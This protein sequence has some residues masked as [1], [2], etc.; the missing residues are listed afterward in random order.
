MQIKAKT[1]F[2][3]LLVAVVIAWIGDAK[4]IS[5]SKRVFADNDNAKVDSHVNDIDRTNRIEGIKRNEESVD[6]DPSVDKDENFMALGGDT[7]IV[8]R[9]KRDN[10]DNDD[11]TVTVER[12]L[13]Y[14]RRHSV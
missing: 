13:R 6:S 4:S 12:H 1:V 8:V 5:R 14:N 7:N 9:H 10:D 3:V 11:G 2:V